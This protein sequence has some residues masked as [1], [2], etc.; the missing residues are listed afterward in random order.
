MY[1]SILS[2]GPV[3]ELPALLEGLESGKI[4][5]AGIDVLE[6][7]KFDQLTDTQR[8]NYSKLFSYENVIVTPHIGGWSHESLENINNMILT[9]VSAVI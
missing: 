4:I 3:V 9:F 1:C 6:N 8:E 5:A 2:R 7:E